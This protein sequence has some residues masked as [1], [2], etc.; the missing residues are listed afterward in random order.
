MDDSIQSFALVRKNLRQDAQQDVEEIHEASDTGQYP[1]LPFPFFNG[2]FFFFFLN[3]PC[4]LKEIRPGDHA[5]TTSK[6]KAKAMALSTTLLSRG[7][8]HWM[9]ANGPNG[10]SLPFGNRAEHREVGG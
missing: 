9:Q 2:P 4:K 5:T 1:L 3:I 8:P 10:S 7:A 6:L